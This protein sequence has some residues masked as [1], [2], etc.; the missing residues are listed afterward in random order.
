MIHSKQAPVASGEYNMDIHTPSGSGSRSISRAS[1]GSINS[2]NSF[3]S[4]LNF[5]KIN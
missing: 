3:L 1:R 5:R 4:K 2:G